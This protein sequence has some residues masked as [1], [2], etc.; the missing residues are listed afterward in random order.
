MS[1]ILIALFGDG[2]RKSLVL[3]SPQHRRGLSTFAP[4][5]SFGHIL[6]DLRIVR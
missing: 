5:K 2:Y 6:F 4:G 1:S 3:E